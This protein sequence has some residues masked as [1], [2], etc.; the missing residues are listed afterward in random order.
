MFQQQG[1]SGAPACIGDYRDLYSGRNWCTAAVVQSLRLVTPNRVSL[2]LRVTE[3]WAKICDGRWWLNT[4]L[5]L[6]PGSWRCLHL[7]ASELV[8]VNCQFLLTVL[9]LTWF[10]NVCCISFV[11]ITHLLKPMRKHVLRFLGGGCFLKSCFKQQSKMLLN[12]TKHDCLIVCTVRS[13]NE[14]ESESHNLS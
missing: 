1:N 14:E 2:L 5:L 13:R 6:K 12:F 10:Q 3:A 9:T 4:S 7:G 11:F 8:H